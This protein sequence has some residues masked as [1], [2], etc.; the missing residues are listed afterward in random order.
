[1]FSLALEQQNVCTIIS[2]PPIYNPSFLFLEARLS[3]KY[4][5]SQSLQSAHYLQRFT[6]HQLE[7]EPQILILSVRNS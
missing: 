3:R 1:M 2:Q 5:S 4:F 7:Y 6:F